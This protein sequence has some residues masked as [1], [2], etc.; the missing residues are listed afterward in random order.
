MYR[1]KNLEG[2]YFCNKD[3]AKKIYLCLRLVHCSDFP[4]PP[5]H[6]L[7]LTC[8]SLTPCLL[9]VAKGLS[10]AVLRPMCGIHVDCEDAAQ[11]RE[12]TIFL[13]YILK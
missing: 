7:L 5:L 3:F 11:Q 4:L 13:G 1:Y 6:P 12:V 2:E 10:K 8:K 9:K